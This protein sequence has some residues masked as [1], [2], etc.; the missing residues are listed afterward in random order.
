MVMKITP[1][2]SAS[3]ISDV[4]RLSEG[5]EIEVVTLDEFVKENNL[6]IGLIKLDVEGYELDV[7]NGA[8]ETIKRFKPVVSIAVYHRGEDFFEIPRLVKNL[9]PEYKL[10]FLNLNAENP[11]FER[12]LLAYTK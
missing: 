2:G 7:L 1:F 10:R 12:I 11:I 6:D 9:V 8:K 3:F 4:F 5:K